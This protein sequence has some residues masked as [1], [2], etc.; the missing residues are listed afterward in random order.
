MHFA[1]PQ[2]KGDQYSC[3]FLDFDIYHDYDELTIED[4]ELRELLDLIFDII[5]YYF[6]II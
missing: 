5:R 6:D 4:N 3:L 2:S 1:E